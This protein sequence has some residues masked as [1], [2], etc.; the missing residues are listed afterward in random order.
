MKRAF[1]FGYVDGYGHGLCDESG[2]IPRRLTI[3]VPWTIGNMDTGLLRNG[4]HPD[5]YDGKVFWTVGGHPGLPLWFAFVWWDRS[6]DTRPNSNS[7]F[8]V[9][10]FEFAERERAFHF[11]SHRFPAV[12]ARQK[13]TLVVQEK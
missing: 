2:R 11:A 6:G 1:Y 12:V 8:Y 13:H 4:K 3:Q 7:G 5:I 9:H 10:G